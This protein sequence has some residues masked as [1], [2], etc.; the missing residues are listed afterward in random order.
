MEYGRS[1]WHEAEFLGEIA[2]KTGCGLLLDLNNL[3]VSSQ[4]HGWA[5][6]DWL[7]CYPLGQVGE[8]HLAGHERG[9]DE[10]G[11]TLLIDSHGEPVAQPVYELLTR[12]TALAG[13][14]PVL[15]ERDNNVPPL[16]DLLLEAALVR[17]F[18]AGT[19]C[20]EVV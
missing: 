14:R 9:V 16:T 15:I 3:Y 1:T 11:Q 6:G 5:I 4:N 13:P 20:A 17:N 8:I 18:Q 10:A 19:A 12:V 7:D 2:R